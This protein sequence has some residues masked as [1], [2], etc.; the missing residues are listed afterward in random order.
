[1]PKRKDLT[2]EKCLMKEH[3]MRVVCVVICF[4]K[5]HCVYRLS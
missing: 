4:K 1:M 2:K 5:G 3:E